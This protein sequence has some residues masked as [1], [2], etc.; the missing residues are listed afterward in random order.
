MTRMK[1]ARNLPPGFLIYEA[2][3]NTGYDQ[4]WQLLF[5]Y[6]QT[7]LHAATHDKK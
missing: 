2:M 6:L 1:S 4:Q 3:V 5:H 7:D